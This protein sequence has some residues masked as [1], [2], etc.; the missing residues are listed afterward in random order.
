MKPKRI[1][2]TG[3]AG[4]IGSHV[5]EDLV[6]GGYEVT[7]LDDLS[8]G[9][10]ENLAS[11]RDS[12]RFL[13]GSILDPAA[14]A[15]AMDGQRFVS[16]LAAQLEI[17]RC[18]SNPLA[19]LESNTIGTLRL[20]EAAAAAGIEKFVN[21]SSACIY[22]QA[23][24]T[25]QS[26]DHP[27]NPNWEYGVSKLAAEKY[28]KIFHDSGRLQTVSL[29]FAII[30]G[31]RE[32]CGRVITMFLR[33][34]LLGRPPVIFGDGMQV[35]DFTYVGDAVCLHRLV[36]E[37]PEADGLALNVSTGIGTAI[38]ELAETCREVTGVSAATVFEQTS[39]GTYSQ[40]MPDRVRLPQELGTMHL[41]PGR[42]WRRLGWRS[43]VSLR[44]GLAREWNWLRAN[45]SHWERLRI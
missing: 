43:Q 13:H 14:L 39:E 19:D 44:E 37:R 9:H 4:F 40:A 35:R 15:A 28:A 25:P 33:R 11:V 34:A 24:A 26:E 2:V 22:G 21:A 23:V 1:L 29:R 42:A 6:S 36:L 8:S 18:I 3:G 5:V 17:A 32:W 45:P 10:L 27:A 7:V 38:R 16:H 31:E 20:L 41:D 12:I 30:Y